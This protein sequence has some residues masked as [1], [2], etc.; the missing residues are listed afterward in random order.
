MHHATITSRL[1]AAPRSWRRIGVCATAA[2]GTIRGQILIAFLIMSVIT[3]TLGIHA[4]SGIKQA[5]VLVAETFDRSLM[6]INYARAA[7]ADFAAMEA[8]FARRW[9]ASDPAA[10]RELDRRVEAIAQSL[11]EDLAIAAERSQSPRAARAAANVQRAVAAWDDVRRE[12]LADTGRS[13]PW[14]ALDGYAATVDREIDLLVNYT[15]GDGFSYRQR[16]RGVVAADRRLNLAATAAALLLSGLV[17]WLLTRRIVGPVATA[18]AVARRIARG[19]LDGAF[20]RGGA[21]ELGALLAA[22]AVMRDNIRAM[23]EREVAQRRSAQARLA[24]ALES[25]REGVVVVDAEGR[26]VLANAQAGEFF[27]ADRELLRPGAFFTGIADVATRPGDTG[28]MPLLRLASEL[29]AASEV[30]LADG[31]WL[32]VSRSATRDGGFV[33]VCSDVTALRDK[34]TMLEAANLC[35][36]AALG[37]MSQGLCLYDADNRLRVVNRRFC[38]IFRLSP[39]R[40]TPGIPFREVLELSVAAGNHVGRTASDLLAEQA[41]I[42]DLRASGD[43][44]FQELSHGRVVAISRQATADGGWVATYEDVTERRRAEAQIVFMARHDALTGLPNRVLFCERVEQALAQVG[45]DGGFAVLLLD[46]DRFKAVNDTLGHPIGDELLRSVAERLQAC[47]REVDTV[48]RL[49]GDEFV[50]VQ[51]GLEKAE[52]AT[53]LAR[54]IIEVLSEPYDI[55]GHRVMIGTSIGISA[56]PGDGSSCGKLLKNADVALYRAK[57]DGRGTWRFFEPEM[58]ARLQARRLLELDLREALARDEFDLFFQ[59][60]F[61]LGQ[62]R[63]GGFEALLRWRHP[64]RGMVSPA[65]FIPLAEEIGLIVPLGEWILRRACAEASKWPGHVNVA[66]NVSPAQFKSGR[67]LQSVIAALSAAELPAQRLEMEITESV[68][69]A[70]SAATL[71][72]LHALRDLGVRISMDDFGTGYSSLS[73]LRSFPFDKIKIDQSFIRDLATTEDSGAIVRAITGLGRSLGMRTTA[74]G[75]E[76]DEQL[77]W[78]RAEGCTEVQGYFFSPPRPAGEIPGL[79]ARWSGASRAAA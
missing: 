37:N 73:Y 8:A 9:I 11:A 63:I 1:T 21:D 19:E 55:D 10:Q 53:V 5:G 51:A 24:D 66:V 52:D 69:L 12:L 46:L 40:V 79:L 22:M 58:D 23:M 67:L 38:E 17:T 74:E 28:V 68:L 50:I 56:A 4:A 26:I 6:S 77:T 39:E 30:H 20:P 13:T 57:A 48:A 54:R 2:V 75:V 70:D 78:L 3:A 43:T 31:R 25:S 14:Q 76:T 64:A 16:A 59:P 65:E 44:R 42:A 45:R 32:R 33:A 71:A 15:A 61:D 41:G 47:V 60:L 36:D 29:Q 62:D 72:T 34:T 35:L 7:S 49:G 27:A 18:S